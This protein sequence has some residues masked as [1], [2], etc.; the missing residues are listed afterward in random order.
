MRTL[1]VKLTWELR[2]KKDAMIGWI[3]M[4]TGAYFSNSYDYSEQW[5]NPC[6]RYM[7]QFD[8]PTLDEKPKQLSAYEKVSSVTVWLSN[9][10]SI[11]LND[12]TTCVTLSL[13]PIKRWSWQYPTEILGAQRTCFLIS[14]PHQPCIYTVS[15]LRSYRCLEGQIW[16]DHLRGLT[17]RHEY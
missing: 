8:R 14:K 7:P 16:V 2:N 5:P 1:T 10:I 17:I 12:H 3:P 9:Y 6:N 4:Y 15:R 13:F 11:T